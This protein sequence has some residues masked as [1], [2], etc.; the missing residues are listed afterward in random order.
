[1]KIERVELRHVRIPLV[2]PF[3]TSRWREEEKTCVI[4]KLASGSIVGFGECAV[5]QGPWYSYETVRSALHIM[6]EF[7][8][9]SVLG[10]DF[11]TAGELLDSVSLVRG[12]NMAKASFEMAFWDLAAKSK[13]VSL[14]RM[15]G[16]TLAKIVSGVSVGLQE[17]VEKLVDVVESFLGLGYPR[18][19]VKVKPGM[20]VKLVSGLRKEYPDT[21]LMVD[22]NGAYGSQAMNVLRELD[23][24]GLLMIEQPF[25]WDDLVDHASLQ[26]KI[27]T[28]VC[29]DESVAGLGDLRAA[30]ELGSCRVL[31][32]KPARVGGLTVARMLHDICLSRKMPVWCGGLLETGIGR[33]ANV[34]L[35][36]LPGFVMPNDI[37]ASSRY[38]RDDIVRPEFVLNPDGTIN[39]PQGPGIGVD[40]LEDRLDKFTLEKKS[41]PS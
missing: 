26:K 2:S 34:A 40:V 35:A 4:V 8:V 13:N 23:Q 12:H 16:G 15:L 7:L 32:I 22:G 41:F 14:S 3:E 1:M 18:V 28:P 24:F 33:A 30:L 38:F 29:L 11:K 21:P 20:D 31:N 19:K 5:S 37:S 10:H 17:T 36:S 27:R 9:P 25:A 39:V 6:E